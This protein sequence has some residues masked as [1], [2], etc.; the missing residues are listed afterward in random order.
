ML[1]IGTLWVL[2]FCI[3]MF[4]CGGMSSS[5][6]TASGTWQ[7][8]L[9]SAS[10]QSGQQ[11]EQAILIVFLKQNGTSLNG[12][13]N[14][15]VQQSSCFSNH[16]VAGASLQGQV[17]L[18]GGEAISNLQLS[19]PLNSGGAMTT[20]L[21]MTGAMQSD[22]NTAAGIFNLKPNAVASCSIASGTFTLTRMNLL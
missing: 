18:P 11:G 8:V 17:N 1:R 12:T 5:P 16:G 3:V 21:N 15:V 22:A 20:T 19:G 4:G 9:T 14:T 10:A 7:A 6:K 13:I 2:I